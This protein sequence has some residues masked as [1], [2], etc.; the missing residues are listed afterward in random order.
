[1]GGSRRRRVIFFSPSHREPGGAEK[2]A[3][4]IAN[5]LAQRGWEVRVV[6]RGSNQR[7]FHLDRSANLTIFEVPNFE[8]SRAGTVLY[9]VT[10][11]VVG[12][13]WARRRSVYLALQLYSPLMAAGLCGR[14][15]RR[16]YL[17]LATTSGQSGEAESL[18]GGAAPRGHWSGAAYRLDRRVR[19]TLLGRADAVLAQTDAAADELGAYVAADRIMVLPSPVGTVTPPPLS[20]DRSVLFAGT[21]EV[22]KDLPRLLD[23]WHA[24]LARLPDARLTLVGGGRPGDLLPELRATVNGDGALTA[25]VAVMEWVPDL[26]ALLGAHDVFVLPSVTEGMSNALVEACA[27]GRVV[28]AS[29]IAANRFVLGD[30]YPLLYPVGDTAA[31]ATALTRALTDAE[32]RDEARTL[33]LTRAERFSITSVMDTLESLLVAASET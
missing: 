31:L 27:W 22:Q 33:A 7:R 4:L 21:F 1:M 20:G 12:S 13:A 9:L 16:P 29:D 26:A 30:S 17:A 2:R 5:Q 25:S 3:R 6:A 28:V 10:A 24:V 23:A 11:I 18:E 8:Y 15:R 14:L 32:L 19:R